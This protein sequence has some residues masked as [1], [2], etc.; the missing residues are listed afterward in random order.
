MPESC[1]GDK[2]SITEIALSLYETYVNLFELHKE[3]VS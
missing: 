2:T 1:F 3:S